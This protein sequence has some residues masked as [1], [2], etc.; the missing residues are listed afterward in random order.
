MKTRRK[1]AFKKPRDRLRPNSLD[2]ATFP[3]QDPPD[4][5]FKSTRTFRSWW[6][7]IWSG[8]VRDPTGKHYRAIKKAIWLYLYFLVVANWRDGTLF[9]RV[10]KIAAETGFGRR[11]ISRWLRTLRDKG[12]ITTRSTGRRLDISITK[13]RPI[14]RKTDP[15]TNEKV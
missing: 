11:S 6:T 10:E 3:R 7:H 9:R 1:S 8:L 13:W 2:G 14:S 4:L 15:H 12:Y 5:S